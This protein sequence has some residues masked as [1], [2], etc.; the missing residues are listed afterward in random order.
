MANSLLN[1]NQ[2][3]HFRHSLCDDVTDQNRFFGIS[4]EDVNIPFQMQGTNVFFETRV[5]SIWEMEN[6]RVIVMTDDTEWDPINV[7]IA[8]VTTQEATFDHDLHV[9]SDVFSDTRLSEH[10]IASVN[11]HTIKREPLTTFLPMHENANNKVDITSNLAMLNNVSF[12]AARNRH[13]HVT[14]EEVARHFRCGIETARRTL[15]TT[16]QNGTRHAIHP[17]TRRY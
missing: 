14:V 1:P 17:L 6:C 5:P 3:R 15:K 7:S 16:T 9:I 12:L 4:T 8:Q 11:I 13:S 2:M 10:L